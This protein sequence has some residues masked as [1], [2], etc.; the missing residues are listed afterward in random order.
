MCPVCMEEE[1]LYWHDV[2]RIILPSSK[3]PIYV[4]FYGKVMEEDYLNKFREKLIEDYE[5]EYE[6]SVVFLSEDNT[7]LP[8]DFKFPNWWR[9]KTGLYCRTCGA[10]IAEKQEAYAYA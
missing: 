8:A 6:E 5:P 3:V 4:P 1:E 9:G 2:A 10:Y 7:I